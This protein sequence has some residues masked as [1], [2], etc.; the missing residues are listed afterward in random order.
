VRFHLILKRHELLT[1]ELLVF[2]HIDAVKGFG[3]LGV[4]AG[5]AA[6]DLAV[7]VFV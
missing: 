5:L 7:F 6:A 2:V 4:A 1:R 3:Q